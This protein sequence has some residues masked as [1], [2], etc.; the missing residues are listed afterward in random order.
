MSGYFI[1]RNILFKNELLCNS[2]QFEIAIYS[3]KHK[4]QTSRDILH[5]HVMKMCLRKEK[6]ITFKTSLFNVTAVSRYKSSV[7]FHASQTFL[8]QTISNVRKV[9]ARSPLTCYR[10]ILIVTIC[11]QPQNMLPLFMSFAHS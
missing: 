7:V 5:H 4:N 6:V 1:L 10:G 2:W 9:Y 3:I 11:I 8:K